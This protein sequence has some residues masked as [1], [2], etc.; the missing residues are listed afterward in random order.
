MKF[1]RGEENL[2]EQQIKAIADSGAD[3]VVA[4]GKFGDMALHYV[5]KYGLMA[6]RL[7]SKFDIRRLCKA[8][9]AT[10]LPRLVIY[11]YFMS[12]HF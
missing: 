4:G 6:V 1:S 11:S 12:Q 10:A 7:N 9:N 8:V 2:L 5:N 3:V